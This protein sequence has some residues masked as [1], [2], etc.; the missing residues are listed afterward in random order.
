M[1]FMVRRALT[2]QPS[3]LLAGICHFMTTVTSVHP[4]QSRG[5]GVAQLFLI[6][7]QGVNFD[8][9]VKR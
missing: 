6:E 3:I 4:P 2:I 7:T 9:A 1:V 5:N 8:M